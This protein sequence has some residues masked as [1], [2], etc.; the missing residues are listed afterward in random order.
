MEDA[1]VPWRGSWW[2]VP[3]KLRCN[4]S[5]TVEGFGGFG[6]EEAGTEVDVKG[7][8]EGDAGAYDAEVDF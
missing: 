3:F 8:H 7:A 1:L 4:G 6:R 5:V 2:R